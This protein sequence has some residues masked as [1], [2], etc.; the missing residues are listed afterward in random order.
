MKTKFCS[1]E[2]NQICKIYLMNVY[3]SLTQTTKFRLFQTKEF[4]IDNFEY[5]ENGRNFSNS[6]ENTVE[7]GEIA[8][9]EQF[10]LFFK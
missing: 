8:C 4:A 7:K 3:R 1:E 5:D 9:Y 2:N 6:L 10:L